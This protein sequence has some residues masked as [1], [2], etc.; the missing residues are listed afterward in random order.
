MKL[1]LGLLIATLGA[2]RI[3]VENEVYS[4]LVN[5]LGL[6]FRKIFHNQGENLDMDAQMISRF[7]DRVA[8]QRHMRAGLQ[9]YFAFPH[10]SFKRADVAPT[11]DVSVDTIGGG[12]Y[13]F[14][15]DSGHNQSLGV[16]DRLDTFPQVSGA[17]FNYWFRLY[18]SSDNHTTVTARCR[19]MYSFG[20]VTSFTVDFDTEFDNLQPTVLLVLPV[21]LILLC[22]FSCLLTLKAMLRTLR[23]YRYAKASLGPLW[24]ENFSTADATAF[25]NL[26]Y[27]VVQSAL[28]CW[29]GINFV[30]PL[31]L[32]RHVWVLA[33]NVCLIIASWM[34]LLRVY[35]D[36]SVNHSSMSTERVC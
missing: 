32:S 27:V 4:T 12:S 35:D 10:T 2:V 20:S 16:F 18:L 33:G 8:C 36:V 21:L 1:I 9:N 14:E 34:F 19:G 17:T 15:L 23:I 26:W 22:V 30:C 3:I 11:V 7:S 6:E 28:G 31:S 24:Y 25:F 13:T 5:D 29:T